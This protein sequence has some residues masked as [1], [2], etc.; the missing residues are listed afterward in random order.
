[1]KKLKFLL[2]AL[3]ISLLLLG[4]DFGNNHNGQG[5][6][7]ENNNGE[8]TDNKKETKQILSFSVGG[9]KALALVDDE[10]DR[11]AIRSA[12]R[13]ATTDSMIMK[14][15]E[16][17]SM[18]S[19]ITIPDGLSG[20]LAPINYIAQSPADDADEIYIVFQY[21]SNFWG[22]Y[23]EERTDEWGNTWTEWVSE[24]LHIGQLIC[25]SSDGTYDDILLTDDGTWKWLYNSSKDSIAFDKQGYMYYLV[26]ENSGNSYTN[27]IYKYDPKTKESERLTAPVENTYY[28]KFQVSDDGNWIFVKANRWN[29]NNS[30]SYLR[31]IPTS[32][33]N[34]YIDFFYSSGNSGWVNSWIYDNRNES[35]YYN[36]DGTLYKIPLVDGTFDKAN[37]EELFSG[38][39]NSWFSSGDIFEWKNSGSSNYDYKALSGAYVWEYDEE[40]DSWN[41]PYKYFYFRNP[42]TEEQEIVLDTVLGYIFAR[43]R[44]SFINNG[45]SVPS[46][47][48][49]EDNNSNPD[50]PE[51]NREYVSCFAKEI[52]GIT[53]YKDTK[54][55][56]SE[57][58]EN[59]DRVRIYVDYDAEE[60][61]GIEYHLDNHKDAYYDYSQLYDIKFDAFANVEGYEMLAAVA[62]GKKN[63]EAL[64]AIS[65][66][67]LNGLFA[68]LL[69]SP[70]YSRW[71]AGFFELYEHNFYAD[72]LFD[73]T[74]GEKVDPALLHH[75]PENDLYF[76]Y[77]GL[78]LWDL[79]DWVSSSG[80]NYTWRDEYTTQKTVTTGGESLTKTVVD[81]EKVLEKLAS[82]C[83]AKHIDF[84][85][86]AFKDDVNYKGLY[87]DLINEE[88]IEFLDNPVRIS[89][90]IQYMDNN[91]DGNNGHGKFLS[92]TCF[93]EGTDEPAYELKK[94]TSSSIWWG[95]VNNFTPS[96]G[97]SLYGTY[98][99]G[100]VE[101]LDKDG[102]ATGTYVNVMDDYRIVNTLVAENGFYFQNALLD[103]YEE[104]SGAHQIQ[105]YS[106]QDNTVTNLFKNVTKNI[107]IV[108]YCAAGD[109]VYYSAVDGT[110]VVNAKVDINTLA[111]TEL[112]GSQK[113]SQII[114]VK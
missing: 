45:Y 23:N 84:K 37:R 107:E 25:V 69:E 13:N 7:N 2:A 44:D 78:G 20:S 36:K 66:A 108:T 81:A 39:S 68:N 9:S 86:T 99:N 15:M 98:N 82:Y 74:T 28:D 16:D 102:K 46:K 8:N 1:M 10:A 85:L 41:D 93:K 56:W 63:L 71:G 52:D 32:N 55:Y 31:A 42:K 33:P 92:L 61:D 79:F 72:V 58:D 49:Y 76:H 64:K 105:Y 21:E 65:D 91:W 40:A 47:Y 95:N 35:F 6:N 53:Y 27:M 103:E 112:N 50:Y 29:S 26:S 11:S 14:I 17:G 88:A 96:Y 3:G 90:L 12:A 114:S 106:V 60:E 34:E 109:Y 104:E 100:L 43:A 24:N 97:K 22:G 19:F 87:T 57:E 101:I 111:F 54:W 73:K 75:N 77:K 89:L 30:T 48:Y 110:K 5:N 80:S 51:L 62:A 94:D 59:G 4:C 18:E 113:L 67:G 83:S 38:D 70:Y